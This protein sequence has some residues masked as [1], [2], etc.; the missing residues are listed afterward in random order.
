MNTQ[1]LIEKFQTYIVQI[2]SET[3]TGTGFFLPRHQVIVTNYH[4]ITGN[5]SVIVKGELM[6]RQL[7]QVVYTNPRWDIALIRLDQ[8]IKHNEQILTPNVQVHDGEGVIA[9][10]HPYGLNYTSTQGVISKK[11]RLQDGIPYIQTDTPINPGNSGGPLINMKGQIVG[12]N[13]FIIKD[14]NNLGF[15]L[16]TPYIYGALN[17][18]LPLSKSIKTPI[19][20]CASCLMPVYKGYV[21]MGK[22]CLTCGSEVELPS[23]EQTKE[24]PVDAD[25]PTGDMAITIENMLKLRGLIPEE[26]RNGK[27]RWTYNYGVVNMHIIYQPDS[28]TVFIESNLGQLPHLNVHELYQFMLRE[29]NNKESHYFFMVQENIYSCAAVPNMNISAKDLGAIY[30]HIGE[31]SEEYYDILNKRFGVIPPVLYDR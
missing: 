27:N 15:A 11:D 8:K 30:E 19:T 10:G 16:P 5:W 18:Y 1:E 4:V 12:M 13:T 31:K 14:A 21:D 28:M 26:C 25:Q 2:A 7:A 6:K 17:Q 3:G 24:Q 9:I 23:E 20:A 29:N 22:Y